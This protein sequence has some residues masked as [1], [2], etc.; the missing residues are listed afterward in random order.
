[1]SPALERGTCCG[2]LNTQLLLQLKQFPS[3]MCWLINKKSSSA[4]LNVRAPTPQSQFP[5][6]HPYD[7]TGGGQRVRH[8][9]PHATE[10]IGEEA[11]RGKVSHNLHRYPPR[12]KKRHVGIMSR[13]K[14]TDYLILRPALRTEKAIEYNNSDS[15][16]H[17]RGNKPERSCDKAT[18]AGRA[19]RISASE[20]RG[21]S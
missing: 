12:I 20:M 21:G 9:I 7:V 5:F 18:R 11:S 6:V 15:I 16:V 13:T 8:D 1:M 2:I 4:I 3:G 17:Q 10:K 19:R 14:M